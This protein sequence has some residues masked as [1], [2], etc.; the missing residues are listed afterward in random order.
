MSA[1]PIMVNISS[2][3]KISNT[4]S[5]LNN[6]NKGSVSVFCVQSVLLALMCIFKKFKKVQEQVISAGF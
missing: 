2:K 5:L 1:I 4:S 3:I 6:Y